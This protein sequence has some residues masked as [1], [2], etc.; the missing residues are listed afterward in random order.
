MT[1]KQRT[2]QTLCEPKYGKPIRILIWKNGEFD[3]PGQAITM[4]PKHMRSWNATLNYLTLVLSPRFGAV[5]RLYHLNTKK[6]ITCLQDIKPNEKYLAVGGDKVKFKKDGYLVVEGISKGKLSK[7]GS[8]FEIVKNFN[9]KSLKNFMAYAKKKKRTIVYF[10]VS[11]RDCQTPIKVV[12]TQDDLLDYNM[13]LEYLAHRLDVGEGI[14]HLFQ[15]NGKIINDPVELKHGELY[16]AVPHA[17]SFIP[18]DYREIFKKL[19]PDKN[20]KQSNVDQEDINEISNKQTFETKTKKDVEI[21]LK[22]KDN[23]IA[24]RDNEEIDMNHSNQSSTSGVLENK[25]FSEKDQ[26][27][28]YRSL[29]N[30]SVAAQHEYAREFQEKVDEIITDV[31]VA[32]KILNE[33]VDNTTLQ[34]KQ[35]AALTTMHSWSRLLIDESREETVESSILQY[36]SSINANINNQQKSKSNIATETRFSERNLTTFAD[37]AQKKLN[38]QQKESICPFNCKTP[39]VVPETSDKDI[40]ANS[41]SKKGVSFASLENLERIEQSQMDVVFREQTVST[42]SV[43]LNKQ[44]KISILKHKSSYEEPTYS[45]EDLVKKMP[46]VIKPSFMNL[47]RLSAEKFCWVQNQLSKLVEENLDIVSNESLDVTYNMYND[48][49]QVDNMENDSFQINSKSES[50]NSKGIQKDWKLNEEVFDEGIQAEMVRKINEIFEK[51]TQTVACT[52]P[53]SRKQCKQ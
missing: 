46:V 17:S 47:S 5:R 9:V 10:M 27:A 40:E 15:V 13:I 22:E 31:I 25:H 39:D 41:I 4:H 26:S 1:S 12:L 34:M 33:I 48:K 24:K 14:Q 44:P 30:N 18:L 36:N 21:Q 42:V 19:L 2:W 32:E 50:S 16:I 29:T 23:E 53:C 49:D 43:D 7:S 20:P 11:G 51:E 38:E 37:L 52:K 45:I 6:F 28:D 3:C 35:T 8:D